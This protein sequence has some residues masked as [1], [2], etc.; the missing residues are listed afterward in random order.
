MAEFMSFVIPG[1]LNGGLYAMVGI[2]IILVFKA[3]GIVSLAHGQLLA[4][5]ALV[6]WTALVLMGLPLWLSLLLTLIVAAI[7]GLLIERF[8][9]RPLIGQP[10]FSAFLMTFAIFIFLSGIWQLILQGR[11]LGYPPF[12]AAEAIQLGGI[13]IN[14]VQLLS[15]GTALLVF[16]ILMLFFRYM[17]LGLLMKAT[18]EDH[19]LAQ[20]VGI[21]VRAVFSL[22]WAISAVVAS[23][24]GIALASATAIHYPLPWVIVKGLIVAL[25]GGLQS[26]P[27]ALI[28]GLVLGVT[29]NVAAGY[30]DPIVGGGVRDTAAYVFLLLILL[31]RPQGLFGSRRI[32]RI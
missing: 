3:T 8:F 13:E 27:G 26:I 30:L 25:F 14:L 18:A 32:E 15:F 24:G 9:I 1:L 20:S 22:T 29:E 7:M 31:V 19:Q 2:A 11:A 12:S 16:L 17:R 6:F 28:A 5:G 10:V 23:V 21:N 4:F